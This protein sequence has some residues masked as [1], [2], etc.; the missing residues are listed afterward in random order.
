MTLRAKLAAALA[1]SSSQ[2]PVSTETLAQGH[3]LRATKAAL[4]EMYQSREVAY[5][6]F[7]KGAAKPVMKWWATGTILNANYNQTSRANRL[8]KAKA[9]REAR[10]E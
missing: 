5:C 10:D 1:G 6:V 2:V 9:K 7:Y 3:S 8:A 4:I